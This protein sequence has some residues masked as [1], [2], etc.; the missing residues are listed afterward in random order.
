MQTYLSILIIKRGE[1][2]EIYK[3]GLPI[4]EINAGAFKAHE[5][6][7]PNGDKVSLS[8]TE[9]NLIADSLGLVSYEISNSLLTAPKE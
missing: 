1:K 8:K 4:R 2:T 5:R 6:V 9:I 3:N 7:M